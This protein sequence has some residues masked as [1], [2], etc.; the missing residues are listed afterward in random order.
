MMALEGRAFSSALASA[1]ALW[2]LVSTGCVTTP[3]SASMTSSSFDLAKLDKARIVYIGEKHD[4]PSHHQFQ[5]RIIR[6]LRQQGKSLTVG[7]EML[8]VTQQP[9]LEEYLQGRLSWIS[10]ARRTAF[11][12]GWGRTSPAYKRILSWC[13]QN[14]IPVLALNAPEIVA[15]KLAR[16]QPL[17]AQEKQLIPTYPEPPA[18]FEQFQKAIGSHHPI[19][20]SARRYYEAQRAWDQ[21]MAGR[22]LTWLSHQTGTLVVMLGRFH[23]DPYTGVPW[24]VARKANVHQLILFPI[25]RSENSPPLPPRAATPSE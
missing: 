10:F 21:T 12:R 9:P 20:H 17:T 24:Y 4:Q 18:G 23:A 22:I 15:R 13:R 1:V 5:E 8:D 7:M 25:A 14:M 11:D 16:N 19:G 6:M 3:P 2:L